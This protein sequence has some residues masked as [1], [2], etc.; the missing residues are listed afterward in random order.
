MKVLILSRDKIS[1]NY[2]KAEIGTLSKFTVIGT[3][4]NQDDA[5]LQE[6]LSYISQHENV[7]IFHAL[8]KSIYLASKEWLPE[9]TADYQ[10]ILFELADVVIYTPTLIQTS[11][12]MKNTVL[13]GSSLVGSLS[14][15]TEMEFKEG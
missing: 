6:R 5:T 7:I 2:F 15:K 1:Q 4:S 11:H 13:K 3:N 12:G 8:K 10:K 9:P 14:I